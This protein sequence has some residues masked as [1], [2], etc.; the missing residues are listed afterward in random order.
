[1]KNLLLGLC[2]FFI[3]VVPASAQKT[4]VVVI[5]LLGDS[6]KTADTRVI[7]IPAAALD[8]NSASSII[9]NDGVGLV[10][11]S[12]FATSAAI[13]MP[14]PVDYTTGDITFK[15]MF[16]ISTSSSGNVQ[17][18]I[19]PRSYDAGDTFGDAASIT[20]NTVAVTTTTGFGRIYEQEMTIPAARLSKDWWY[21]SI[22]RNSGVSGLLSEDVNVLGTSL[23][24]SVK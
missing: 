18:F 15:I 7:S 22:Q 1:M 19:R 5:P 11:Q 10:W 8:Y 2:I 17:F 21:V 23:E 4:K 24:F 3:M 20:Q 13:V 9:D 14:R 6:A 12:S 16:L